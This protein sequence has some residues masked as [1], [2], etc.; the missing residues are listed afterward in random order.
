M[1]ESQLLKRGFCLW[2]FKEGNKKIFWA[3][4]YTGKALPWCHCPLQA[5]DSILILLNKGRKWLNHLS[6][7]SVEGR[8]RYETQT[9]WD[10]WAPFNAWCSVRYKSRKCMSNSGESI[11]FRPRQRIS[12]GSVIFKE[13][14]H[15]GY[16]TDLWKWKNLKFSIIFQVSPKSDRNERDK[17]NS[18]G[19]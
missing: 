13:Q 15:P 8:W 14:R 10:K 19:K 11:H 12:N 9:G 4:N 5:W 3:F 17:G 16:D 7:S 2:L 18:G 6:I 1:C